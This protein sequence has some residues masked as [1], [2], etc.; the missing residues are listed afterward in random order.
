MW[1]DILYEEDE[2]SHFLVF[3]YRTRTLD[4][5]GNIN[6]FTKGY[7]PVTKLVADVKGVLLAYFHTFLNRWTNLFCSFV[8]VHGVNEVTRS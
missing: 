4:L 5:Y 3:Q 7:Q 6:E 8:N 2:D 1:Q